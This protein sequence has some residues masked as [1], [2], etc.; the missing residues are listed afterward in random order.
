MEEPTHAPL[1]N[2]YLY[3]ILH[4]HGDLLLGLF[5]GNIYVLKILLYLLKD[6]CLEIL[7]PAIFALL[8]GNIIHN[9]KPVVVPVDVLDVSVSEIP[10]PAKAAYLFHYQPLS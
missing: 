6:H 10:V 8:A 9:E 7:L 4:R 3:K 2:S 1:K 5:A